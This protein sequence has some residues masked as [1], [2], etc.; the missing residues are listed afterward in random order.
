MLWV[1]DVY[2]QNSAA[3]GIL[4]VFDSRLEMGCTR[5]EALATSLSCI[6][7]FS[8]DGACAIAVSTESRKSMLA[9]NHKS[10]VDASNHSCDPCLPVNGIR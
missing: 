4:P 2:I 5:D 7:S 9:N 10:V 6:L 3:E 1:E 8:S